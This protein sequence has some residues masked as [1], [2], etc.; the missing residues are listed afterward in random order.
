[1][2][3]RGK[4]F[5]SKSVAALACAS[6]LTGLTSGMAPVVAVNAAT[7]DADREKK[8]IV[9]FVDAGDYV[10]DTVCKG[11]QLGTRNSVT[12][13]V[14]GADK[15]T[16]YK[17]GIVDEV[18]NPL[19]NNSAACGGVFTD[20]TW[21]YESNASK[22]D[23]YS[24][25]ESNRY[26][27]NQY[28]NKVDVR[29]LDYKFEMAAGTYTVEVC[30]TDPWRCSQSPTLLLNSEDPTADFKAGKGTKLVADT[31]T[32]QTV[33]MEKAGDLTVS[34]RAS[35]DDNKAINI[36]YILIKDTSI[37]D[38]EKEPEAEKGSAQL[39]AA[40][41]FFPTNQLYGNLP[42]P[43]EGKNGSKIS[44]ASSND[45]LVSATGEVK[46]PAAGKS[47]EVVTLTAT[48]TDGKETV[49]KT[50][51]FTVLAQSSNS[52]I[53]Q[54]SLDQIDITDNYYLGAQNSD[55]EFL[56]KF[57]NDRVLYRFR[58]TAGLDTKNAETYG[59]WE[60][61]LIAGHSVG[62][63]LTAVAQAI[64]AT[65]DKELE[66]KLADIIHGLKECQ[67]KVGTGYIFG[68]MFQEEEDK[69]KNIEIQ[70]DILEE[71]ERGKTWV[72]WYT[73]HKIMAG[74]VDTY[75][76]TGN[77]EALEVATKLGDWVYNRVSQWSAST[78]GKVLGTEYGGMN[79]CL[80]ELYALTH[81]E[82]HLKAAEKFDEPNLYKTVTSG[83][84]NTLNKRHANT[85]IPKFLGA[86]KRYEVLDSYDEIKEEDKEYLEYAKKFFDIV[87]EEHIYIT[88]GT[89]DM[90]HFRNG[91]TLDGARTQC[92]NE[93][94]CAYNLLKMAR[95]LYKITG[96]KK[97]ADYYENTL[98]NAIMGAVNIENGSTTYFTPMATG[99][100]KTFCTDDPEDNMFWCCTGS[101]ME[102]FTKLGDS[103]YFK[104]DKN[105]FVNQYIASTVNWKEA[106]MKVT[107]ESDVTTSDIANFKIALTDGKASSQATIHLRVP[108]WIAGSP[109]VKVNGT[110]VKNATVS[111]GYVS[112]DRNWENGDTISIQYPMEVKAYGLSD[113]SSVFGFK[114]G[115]TVLAAKLG[116]SNIAQ[117]TWAGANLTAPLYKVVG[118]EKAS[119]KVTYGATTKQI[120]GTETLTITEDMSVSEYMESINTYLVKDDKESVPTFTL[121]GTDVDENIKGGLTFVPFNTLNNERYGIYWYFDSS[122]VETTPEKIIET[123]EEARFGKSII[124]SI[125]PGYGQYENDVI[126]QLKENN[127]VASTIENGGSTRHAKAGGSFTYN[128]VVNADKK[129]SLLCQFAKADNG[130]TIKITVGDTVIS[131]YTL[132]YKGDDEFFKESFE[133]PA[134]VIKANVKEL[135]VKD[136]SGETKKETVVPVT[137]A[138]AN[139][140]DSARLVGGLYMTLEFSK[141]A[142][143]SELTCT[144][145]SVVADGDAYTVYVPTTA[146]SVKYKVTIADQYGL[147][148]VDDVLVNDAKG[149]KVVLSGE[150]TK[151]T[152]KVFAEDHTTSKEYT[153]TFVKGENPNA[154]LPEATPEAKPEAT[155]AATPEAAPV[156]TPEATPEATPAATPVV[157][158][159]PAPTQSPVV[160]PAP[161]ETKK[162]VVTTGSSTKKAKIVIK[163]KKVVKKGKTIQLKAKLTGVKGKVKWS[164]NKKKIAK[165]S[166]KGKLKG[167]K[168][169]TVKVT[170]KVKNVKASIKVKVK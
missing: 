106:N 94:C 30:S 54:F 86:L 85:T 130:K 108:D 70:F 92:N 33:K 137:F 41:I 72:P 78:K 5:L 119:L 89:S 49:V 97:Y 168:K 162:P 167:L 138:S 67:D 98:R 80:Y 44:W 117:T 76:F 90:E 71:K 52:E 156:A 12:D 55:I 124:D 158:G 64:K 121:Q 142:S 68:A 107:Q 60:N 144:D 123:K 105:L 99:Y 139:T 69:Y 38:E 65:G 42:L 157:T 101:G 91:N 53:E 87:S 59:G 29:Y 160:T 95:E 16:G 27:K 151:V 100:F 82:K 161:E 103:I 84:K 140:S 32:T 43:T 102:N 112:V 21:P 18:S 113:N 35:G 154:E 73:M 143:I 104:K 74:L 14:Y 45:K 141:N 127:T 23:T 165:I 155:P 116:R 26:T 109:V 128:M 134:D 169:G 17:W 170:A 28:E 47:D 6:M 131:E 115:P 150:S 120:L 118:D 148:Y 4:N 81:S 96:E 57:D 8:S 111:S 13:Q 15:Q 125:Q 129:N 9:Y 51:D 10:T 122:A 153:I 75:K 61:S 2:T 56:K 11:D 37:V 147:L 135:S 149:Q 31:P 40:A 66:K 88:G 164:V 63:Y 62:H 3:R 34:L 133:I 79:D 7:K 19:K 46:R 22:E 39:D 166:S 159:S 77:E 58:D 24:K 163:G 126:H 50:Y 145:G 36:C 132:D 146:T 25:Q 152:A 1:M 136:D 20:N 83:Q 114:Y 93:S 48:V 110:V